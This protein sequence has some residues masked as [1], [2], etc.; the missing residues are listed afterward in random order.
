MYIIWCKMLKW[1]RLSCSSKAIFSWGN[2]GR[3]F[4]R[5]F[6]CGKNKGF[7][8]CNENGYAC[9]RRNL[10]EIRIWRR[11]FTIWS[12]QLLRSILEIMGKGRIIWISKFQRR[13]QL[14]FIK[15]FNTWWYNIIFH[16][17]K[18]T[19]DF[20]QRFKRFRSYWNKR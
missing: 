15:W 6:K 7:S 5:F 17:R 8:Q 11:Y 12:F 20:C 2:N 4:S 14:G 16:E 3:M 19:M 18:R 9:S 13:I 1:R 10:Q